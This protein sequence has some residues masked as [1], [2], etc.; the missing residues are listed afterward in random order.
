VLPDI[1]VEVVAVIAL[2]AQVD[3]GL[4]GAVAHAGGSVGGADVLDGGEQG[5][6]AALGRDERLGHVL[7]HAPG[8]IGERRQF[9]GGD[10]PTT[11]R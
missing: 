2:E 10:S 3:A 8:Q 1:A 11:R 9:P 4:V 5:G 6:I 7:R